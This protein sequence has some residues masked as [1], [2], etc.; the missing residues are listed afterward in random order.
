MNTKCYST[1][2]YFVHTYVLFQVLKQDSFDEIHVPRLPESILK[3][4]TE[5]PT[6]T[7]QLT[8]SVVSTMPFSVE[9]GGRKNKPSEYLEQSVYLNDSPVKKK[10]HTKYT[11]PKVLPFTP[12]ALTSDNG[13]TSR[14]NI[15]LL[16]KDTQFV[17]QASNAENFKEALL[18]QQRIKKMGT[19][20]HCKIQRSRKLSKF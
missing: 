1:V 13:C 16:P 14:F 4:L 2:I 18:A 10:K 5:K 15:S 20:E 12:T 8:A 3:Q 11:N 9:Q 7:K 6:K 17:A 19:L